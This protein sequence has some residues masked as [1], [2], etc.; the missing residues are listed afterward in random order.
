MYRI[1]ISIFLCASFSLLH[2]QVNTLQ[3]AFQPLA[4]GD[5]INYSATL[6]DTGW[7][8]EST[9]TL[10]E[11][12]EYELNIDLGDQQDFYTAKSD[13]IAFHFSPEFGILDHNV[14]I[15][16]TD[17]NDLPIGFSSMLT[18]AC[19]DEDF[20]GNL[21]L[22]LLDFGANKTI[23][24]PIANGDSI[25]SIDLPFQILKD[26][27]A[28]PCENEEEI[29][30]DVILTWTSVGDTVIAQA[31]DPDGDGPLDLKI[32]QGIELLD[33]TTYE[34]SITVFNSVEGENITDEIDAE[35]DEHIFFF[36]FTEG[37]FA[38]PS[39]DGNID[40]RSG[41]INYLDAD[42]NGLPIGLS[43]SWTTAEGMTT[44]T[45]RVVLKH[46]PDI[47]S[48]SSS[49]ENGGTDID[50]E[51]PVNKTVTSSNSLSNIQPNITVFPNPTR[52]ILNIKSNADI[53]HRFFYA[54][55]INTWGQV[56]YTSNEM[57]ALNLENLN[58]GLYTL[59]IQ[60]DQD[61]YIKPFL[62][63]D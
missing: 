32:I 7:L 59:R 3:L 63:L 42:Q 41:E 57:T 11:S 55:I 5:E 50:L 36:S 47:K 43:T 53:Q 23:S 28:P 34:M 44:G 13:Q 25:F 15:L 60:T 6:T 51:F 58:S 37:L 12:S 27:S 49:V 30:T 9:I 19:V 4:G 39:G 22:V 17:K 29:I 40:N 24:G 56:V 48:M 18:T 8:V 16:D 46:Q 21:N 10:L 54:E 31:Q 26:A 20:L 45:F 38:S 14:E 61:F 62:K 35:S 2:A 33:N 52:N 1:I